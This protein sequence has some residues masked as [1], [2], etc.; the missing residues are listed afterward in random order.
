MSIKKGEAKALAKVPEWVIDVERASIAWSN[1]TAT[2][3]FVE[4]SQ[5]KK[6]GL[7]AISSQLHKRLVGYLRA[8]ENGP[9]L[10]LAWHFNCPKN[11]TYLCH[12]Q[13]ILLG[14]DHYGI[15][16][17]AQKVSAPLDREPCFKEAKRQAQSKRMSL[18]ATKAA[19]RTKPFANAFT[20]L[21]H[22]LN[23]PFTKQMPF[24]LN[25]SEFGQILLAV[26]P[27]AN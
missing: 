9:M 17:R 19:E 2:G 3:L 22:Q 1:Q 25:I 16:V 10:P 6:Q 24:A 8:L 23:P 26:F 18:Q 13:V 4:S 11:Q 21:T 27:K 12:G 14:P 15:R 20:P 7:P 5:Q